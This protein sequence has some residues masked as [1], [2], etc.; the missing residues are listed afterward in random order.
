MENFA[1]RATVKVLASLTT[2]PDI[3]LAFGSPEA[4]CRSAYPTMSAKK[5]ALFCLLR[6]SAA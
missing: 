6:T 4:G 1:F 2:S 3:V 5:G